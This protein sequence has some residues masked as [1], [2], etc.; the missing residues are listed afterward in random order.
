MGA[1]ETSRNG[2][3][4]IIDAATGGWS[5]SNCTVP[6]V[7]IRTGSLLSLEPPRF[8]ALTQMR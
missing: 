6:V 3:V 7:C 8:R 1:T 2:S 5:C 4:E